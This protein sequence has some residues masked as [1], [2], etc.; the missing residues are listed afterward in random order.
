MLTSSQNQKQFVIPSD[1]DF[2]T[3]LNNPSEAG[4]RYLL[5]SSPE[6]EESVDPINMRYPELY[7]TGSGIA[8]LELEFQ[9]QGV[10]QPD[11]RLYR[12]L[13]VPEEQ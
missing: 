3:A 2:I 4:L 11:W 13:S 7:E 10:G 1:E 8:T 6:V 5:V 9:N 12:V